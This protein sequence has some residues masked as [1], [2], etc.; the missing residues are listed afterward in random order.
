MGNYIAVIDTETNWN[1][2]VM[3]IGVV[4]ADS[5]TFRPVDTKYYILNP[6]SLRGGMYSY[7]LDMTRDNAINTCCRNE[8]MQSLI[9]WF[10]KYNLNKIYAYNA[11]FDM[12]HLEEL[13]FMNW[14]DIMGIAA[15]KQYN[16]GISDCDECF[17]T[18]RLKRNFGVEAIY[19]RLSGNKSYREVHNALTDAL[20]ELDIMRFLNLDIDTYENARIK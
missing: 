13:G 8:A 10:N 19:K 4:I 14:Y 15:Y 9:N 5:S 12:T 6:E 20:D 18:G 3:S 2:E 16:H 17:K 7:E 11:R 1:D